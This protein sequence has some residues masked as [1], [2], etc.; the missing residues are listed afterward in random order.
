LSWQENTH[1][2]HL[3]HLLQLSTFMSEPFLLPS[4][5]RREDNSSHMSGLYLPPSPPSLQ[6][7]PCISTKKHSRLIF[8]WSQS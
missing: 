3:N 7:L 5:L 1:Q 4:C 8:I 2:C 6:H